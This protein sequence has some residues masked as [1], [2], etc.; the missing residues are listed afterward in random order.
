M[1]KTYQKLLRLGIDLSPL[2]VGRREDN[3]PYFCNAEF[4]GKK[5]EGRSFPLI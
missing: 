1:D 4:K 3:A 2:G 5:F